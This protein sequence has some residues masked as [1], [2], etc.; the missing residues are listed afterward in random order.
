MPGIDLFSWIVDLL[1]SRYGWSLRDICNM[2]WEEV[3]EFAVIA[4][5][6]EAEEKNT[7]FKFQFMLHADSETSSKWEDS[8]LPFPDERA[9]KKKIDKSGISQLPKHLL[10][11]KGI[12]KTVK[13]K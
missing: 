13:R 2:Y 12:V 9:P 11:K 10:V 4:A 5:N 8:P 6:L 7:E 3:W 1:A